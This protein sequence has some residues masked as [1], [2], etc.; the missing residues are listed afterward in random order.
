MIGQD[1]ARMYLQNWGLEVLI[2]YAKIWLELWCLGS[3]NVPIF[4]PNVANVTEWRYIKAILESHGIPIDR[5][6]RFGD[7]KV[8]LALECPSAILSIQEFYSEGVDEGS[9][10]FND[11]RQSMELFN[12]NHTW[13]GDHQSL[14]PSDPRGNLDS[15]LYFKLIN[16]A[17]DLA[18]EVCFGLSTCGIPSPEMIKLL[19]KR[20][21]KAIGFNPGK[22]FVDGYM[23]IY[24]AN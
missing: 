10:A 24:E 1:G 7:Y 13:L 14:P 20:G 2:T 12:R 9:F 6:K 16:I 18:D 15:E 22:K 21:V 3:R 19:V 4:I 17:F 8:K 11:I 5:D 23:S